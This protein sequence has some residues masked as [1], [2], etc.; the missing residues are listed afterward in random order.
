V[1]KLP[2]T[3]T[4]LLSFCLLVG[5][6]GQFY[7]SGQDPASIRW[8]Q[9]NTPN[10]QVIFPA[11]FDKQAAHFTTTL[12][13][14]YEHVG[15]TL[16]HTPKK[17]SIVLHSQSSTSNG[18]VIWAPKRME[19]FPTPDQTTYGQEWLD[20]LAVHEFRHVVQMDKL[21]QG[22][23]HILY[24]AFG[25]QAIGGI[26]GLLP[27]WF[28][29]GDA[30][31]TETSLT[32]SGRGRTATFEMEMKALVTENDKLF[33]YEK[34]LRGSY[35]DYV[36]DHY[37]YGYPLVAWTRKQ[38]GSN[39]FEKSI[40]KVGQNPYLLYPF[41]AAIKKE[42]GM[43]LRKLY[44]AAYT[45]L[46]QQWTDQVSKASQQYMLPWNKRETKQFTNYRFPKYV[47]DTTLLVVK[48]GVDQLTKF[49]LLYRNG[50]EKVLHTPGT[51]NNNQFSYASGNY[52]WSEEISDIRWSNRSY[53]CIKIGNI[54]T[55]K[56]KLL[57]QHSRCFSP[58]LSPDGKRIATVEV[59]TQ[60]Y[61][62]LV[63]LD[64]ETGNELDRIIPPANRFLQQPQWTQNGKDLIVIAVQ[65]AGKSLELVDLASGSL[66]VLVPPT[67]RDISMPTDNGNS[68][69]FVCDYNGTNNLYSVDKADKTI[70]PVTDVKFG[71]TDPAVSS[72][73]TIIT[74]ANYSSRGFDV[75]STSN[76][77]LES[78]SL[79][80]IHDLSPKLYEANARQ[81]NFNFQ[82]SVIPEK[83]YTIE[84]Y[85]KLS[86]LVNIHSWAPF[87]YN[88]NN[89]TFGNQTVTPG[90][91]LLS[92]DKLGNCLSSLGYSY[93]QGV[94]QYIADVTYKGF[95]PVIDFSM[96]YG[97]A[98][99]VNSYPGK[100]APV[101]TGESTTATT[102]IYVPLDFTE[103]KYITGITPWV[104]YEYKNEWY[105]YP[106]SK[107]YEQG[108]T[109]LSY[110]ISAYKYM[111]TSLRD[112]A[113]ELGISM[114]ARCTHTPFENVQLGSMWY[115]RGRVYLPG[116][117]NHHSLQLAAGYQKQTPLT[118]LYSS[119][120]AFPRGY[121]TATTYELKTFSADYSLPLAYPDFQL[122]PVL[123]VKRL[124]AN[125]FADY[126]LNSYQYYNKTSKKVYWQ[127]DNPTSTG[128]D[129]TIDF[130]ALRIM[131]PMSA[132]VRMI[133]FPQSETYTSQLL[134]SINFGNY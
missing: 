43:P 18:F 129:I 47:N 74:F 55:G 57:T 3:L 20:Q 42:T 101:T 90:A 124:R 31:N 63:I 61:C 21:N 100:A 13:Y 49:V 93:N 36:P 33:S 6:S 70:V 51:F 22:M 106:D 132:G 123:Y 109:T 77:P 110:G 72:N 28:M 103:G 25:E 35:K 38:Y 118:Y 12:E 84:N 71:V 39:I 80:E 119:Q 14:I 17:I 26:A 121:A 108:M 75:V 133:Y 117:F 94:S 32:S 126:A 134:F 113:P 56:V 44:T 10:F 99:T 88:Y 4:C 52:V 1:H 11:G 83:N 97:G 104:Y 34:I 41:P 53:F 60:N 114:S 130:H 95:Y 115:V 23:T 66:Q 91:S 131:F 122:G 65:N 50:K 112:L 2:L 96:N 92:Q 73:G 79:S 89:L 120:L 116:L 107:S 76:K 16:R 67:H 29:E 81:E 68:V 8:K 15:K 102:Q 54:Y 128:L 46:K 127:T 27:Q 58:V 9:I 19:L 45:D 98:Q 48:S 87:Y 69:L 125:F 59:L 62:S 111:R 30:V 37:Q 82:D 86:H 40:D 24:L 85:S 5:V 7:E 64:A 78:K 105:Y